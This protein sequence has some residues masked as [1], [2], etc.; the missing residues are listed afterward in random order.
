MRAQEPVLDGRVRVFGLVGVLVMV[1][2]MRG[3]PDGPA[4]HGR[5][6]EHAEQEL[7][8]ARSLERLVREIAV[9]ETGDGEHAHEIQRHAHENGHRAHAHHESEQTGRVHQDERQRAYPVDAVGVVGVEARGPGRVEPGQHRA[10]HARKRIV[11]CLRLCVHV[12]REF[13]VRQYGMARNPGCAPSKQHQPEVCNDRLAPAL[14]CLAVS[15]RCS[16]RQ[17][18]HRAEDGS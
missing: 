14:N 9:I 11:R 4:L 6:A 15:A 3:P 10:R 1:A 13:L 5:G 8:N 7:R 2:V 12:S 18:A 17:F 16:V